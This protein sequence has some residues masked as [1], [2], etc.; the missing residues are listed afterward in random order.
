MGIKNLVIAD[1]LPGNALENQDAAVLV[2]G[3]IYAVQGGAWVEMTV[4]PPPQE[5]TVSWPTGSVIS[6]FGEKEPADLL[7]FGKWDCIKKEEAGSGVIY[8]WVRLD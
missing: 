4:G 6:I 8:S 5:I 3:K 1:A 2:N 7:G